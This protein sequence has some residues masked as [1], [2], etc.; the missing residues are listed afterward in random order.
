MIDDPILLAV[1]SETQDRGSDN[2]IGIRESL[3]NWNKRVVKW[4][5]A[6]VDDVKLIS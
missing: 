6:R 4:G 1:S 2:A 3:V 5:V